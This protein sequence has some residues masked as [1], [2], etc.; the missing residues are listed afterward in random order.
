MRRS[1]E[2]VGVAVAVLQGVVDVVGDALPVR[3]RLGVA[4][5]DRGPLVRVEPVVLVAL[6]NKAKHSSQNNDRK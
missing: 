6:K 4:V 2:E 5:G 3:Y 1:L